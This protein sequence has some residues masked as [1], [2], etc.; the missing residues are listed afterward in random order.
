MS[1]AGQHSPL[2]PGASG[3]RTHQLE[4]HR[5]STLDETVRA[6]LQP[7]CSR[8]GMKTSISLNPQ[9]QHLFRTQRPPAESGEVPGPPPRAG[10]FAS[11][12]GGSPWVSAS[13]FGGRLWGLPGAIP[14]RAVQ[15]PSLWTHSGAA[16][17]P[18]PALSQRLCCGAKQ[19]GR[20]SCRERVCLYV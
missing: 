8:A 3:S 9:P 4:T 17:S 20:A 11:Q 5:F 19:I 16:A 15:P 7:G 10:R 12:W 6:L 13:T 14:R 1:A 18:A 2:L